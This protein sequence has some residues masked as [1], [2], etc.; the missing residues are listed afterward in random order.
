MK[1]ITTY[2]FIFSY[3]IAASFTA[4]GQSLLASQDKNQAVQ[5]ED[6]EEDITG[7]KLYGNSPNPVKEKTYFKFEL[8]DSKK[9]QIKL[10]DLLGNQKRQSLKNIYEQGTHEIEMDVSGLEA[11]IYF[12]KFYVDGQTITQRLNIVRR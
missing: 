1:T 9:V 12:Y 3:F 4:S 10:F 6:S 2:F 8:K 11:G 7:F 5:Q